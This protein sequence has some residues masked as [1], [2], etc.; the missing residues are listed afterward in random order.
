MKHPG[1]VCPWHEYK[2]DGRDF[3]EQATV[4]QRL[5]WETLM[6][7]LGA[8]DELGVAEDPTFLADFAALI[9]HTRPGLLS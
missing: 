6:A 8:A 4:Q 7:S 2:A 5:F 1:E 3:F 9:A